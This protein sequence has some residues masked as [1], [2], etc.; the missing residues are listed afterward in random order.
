MVLLRYSMCGRFM[1]TSSSASVAELF[2][3]ELTLQFDRRYNIAPSQEVVGIAASVTNSRPEMRFFHWGLAPFWAKDSKIGNR[4]VNARSETL[5]EKP[6]FRNAF[7][8]RRLLIPANGFYEWDKSARP[9]IPF[10]IGMKDESLFAMAGI[11][12]EW[13]GP[14]NEVVRSC[15][16]I[17]TCGN[18]LVQKVHDRMPV[19]VMPEN[20][21]DWLAKGPLP[22]SMASRIFLPF[23]AD[24]M[25]MR[26]VSSRVNKADYDK[27]DCMENAGDGQV[28]WVNEL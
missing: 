5:T 21:V 11:W 1:L 10:L 26:E 20:Y 28:D 18:E 15:S 22:E 25:R 12:E 6:A 4:L 3:V 13:K 27:P 7:K 23:P 24:L 9:K 16:V 2:S 17:T 19:I 14:E 8:S